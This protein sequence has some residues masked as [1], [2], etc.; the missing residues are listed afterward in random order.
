MGGG[1]DETDTLDGNPLGN[2]GGVIY[3]CVCGTPSL[4]K[5]LNGILITVFLREIYF[6]EIQ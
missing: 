6:S 1:F 2:G 5:F 3:F 4:E